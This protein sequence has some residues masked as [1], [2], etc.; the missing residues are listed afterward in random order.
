M[1]QKSETNTQHIIPK[2]QQQYRTN[3]S[4]KKVNKGREIFLYFFNLFTHNSGHYFALF[5]LF[6][7]LIWPLV[8]NF[9]PLY[10]SAFIF[11]QNQI[12]ENLDSHQGMNSF[13]FTLI[14]YYWA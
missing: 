4:R 2:R 5:I 8:L 11:D 6:L 7:H 3:E 12:D 1:R 13:S 9:Y 10:F 14:K